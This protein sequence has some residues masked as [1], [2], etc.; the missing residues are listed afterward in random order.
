MEMQHLLQLFEVES[1]IADQCP[2]RP[3][4]HSFFELIYILEGQGSF[5]I[6]DH[7]YPYLKDDVFVIVPENGHHTIVR[8]TTSFVFIRFNSKFFSVPESS[9]YSDGNPLLKRIEYIFLNQQR[10]PG[11]FDPQVKSLLRALCL[12]IVQE[13]L[14]GY[15]LDNELL[16]QYIKTMLLV[17]VKN[18]DLRT[19]IRLPEKSSIR[20]IVDYIHQNIKIPDNLRLECIA[21]HVNMSKNYVSEYFRKYYPRSLQQYITDY[22]FQLIEE[23]LRRT[24]LRLGEIA[25]EFGFVGESHLATSFKKHKGISPIRYRKTI[26][27]RSTSIDRK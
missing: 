11:D 3:H 13:S 5:V 6:N 2:I 26:L 12:S 20:A 23:R 15:E 7:R 19:P 27:H 22:R 8:H 25:F 17:I 24:D 4:R 18:I 14:R 1:V 10:L 16:H 9:L 21:D